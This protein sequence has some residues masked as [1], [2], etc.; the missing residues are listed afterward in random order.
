MSI[1]LNGIETAP[2]K[3]RLIAGTKNFDYNGIPRAGRNGILDRGMVWN[4]NRFL[5]P[6][7]GSVLYYPG[8]PAQ[9][10]V[11]KDY[12][13][14]NNHGTMTGTGWERLPSGIFAQVFDGIDDMILSANN[15]GISG[16][17]PRTIK[18]W[19][20]PTAAPPTAAII[21]GMGTPTIHQYYQLAQGFSGSWYLWGSGYDYD[22]GVAPTLNK[23]QLHLVTFDSTMVHWY[24]GMN[25]LFAEI[26]A[27]KN[28]S[29]LDT[30]VSQVRF[31]REIM[32]HFMSD[33]F[34]GYQWGQEI[35]PAALTPA[36]GAAIFDRERHLFGV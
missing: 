25:G 21:C 33:F 14:Q 2:G 3:D 20:K 26:G 15:V 19:I 18:L 12:S 13:G 35:I 4:G 7:R 11:I 8:L 23:W 22:T 27:G 1:L 34:K 36:Q 5:P 16:N 9:G 28:M 32:V 30:D 10:A 17:A 24:L 29:L 6:E 31:G